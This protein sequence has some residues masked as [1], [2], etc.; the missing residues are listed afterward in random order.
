MV[1]I[2]GSILPPSLSRQVTALQATARTLDDV[3]LKLATGLRVNSAI[4]D[5]QNF[6]ASASL[7]NRAADL[8]RLLD[9]INQSIRTVE[10]ASEG[11]RATERII[12][13]AEAFVENVRDDF[14]AG[15]P[16]DIIN[17]ETTLLTTQV[18]DILA[19][20][21]TAIHLGGG[22]IVQQFNTAGTTSFTVAEGVSSLEYLIVGGGGGGGTSTS[23]ST[24]GSGGGGAGGVITGTLNVSAGQSLDVV[25]GAGGNAGAAGN[26]SGTNGGN[27][28]LGLNIGTNLTALGGGAGIGGNGN[29]SAGGSGGGGR[30]GGAGAGL[31]PTTPQGG[32]GNS[33][34]TG[35]SPGG[36]GGGGGG[37]ATTAGG[38]NS[39]VSGGDGGDGFESMITGASV[40]VGG[41]GGGGGA[42]NDSIGVGGVGG[43]G[44]GANDSTAATA[45][46]DGTGGGG[47]GGNNNR[48]GAVGGSGTVVLRYQLNPLNRNT[49]AEAEEYAQILAQ[50]DRIAIDANY[51]GIN[52]LGN[53]DLVTFFN[54]DRTS[55]L[56]TE[57]LDASRLGLGI[58]KVRFLSFEEV[59]LALENLSEARETVRAFGA[60][61]TGDLNI[62]R[63][64]DIFTD[65]TINTLKAGSDDLVVA[66]QN[67]IGADFLALQTRRF[68]QV[69]TL[70][71][72]SAGNS[73]IIDL[74]RP[75]N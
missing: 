16:P 18:N 58:Q 8:S 9:G 68:I 1:D 57:G 21:P 46:V 62:I 19:A 42:N 71:L 51:R 60:T 12:D 2:T 36:H 38:A 48:L 6:F 41:G 25:V 34:G 4:D 24:A 66:D 27:S 56:R 50:L 39:A 61:L 54:E 64:R 23:F 55:F 7:Q 31:Q 53:E 44:S 70:S 33:G 72:A 47:G 67:K 29:G 17:D 40:F 74:V 59:E 5:P 32:L 22:I 10:L 73:A 69:N 15:N 52:L 3:Q 26:N 28:S 11:L 30:G 65:E 14:I 43:G 13:Q 45:G 75:N 37:G 49:T 35:P 20:D 63:A